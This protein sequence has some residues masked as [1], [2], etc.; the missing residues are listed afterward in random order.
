MKDS[1]SRRDFIRSSAAMG[2]GMLLSPKAFAANEASSSKDAINI[3]LIG[4]GAEG[5]VLSDAVLQI[6][7]L[8]PVH[9][10]AVCDIWKPNRELGSRMLGAYKMLGHEATPYT[11]FEDML[12]KE[13]LDCVIVATPDFWH[14]RHT[15]AALK[16][17]LHVYCEKEMSNS[18]VDAKDM[19]LTARAQDKLLQI[20]HQRRSNPKYRFCYDEMI[21]GR[22]ICGKMTTVNGQWNRARSAC[23]DIGCAKSK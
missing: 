12:E 8:Q 10:K 4:Y 19:V 21:A 18:L 20:G 6:S 1:I 16:K 2:A 7:R 3:G 22:N 9:F 15:I 5:Q 17:G 13:D 11:D 23:E 14:A